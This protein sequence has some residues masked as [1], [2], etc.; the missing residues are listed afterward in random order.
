MFQNFSLIYSYTKYLLHVNYE[1]ISVVKSN[2][3]KRTFKKSCP[4]SEKKFLERD[5]HEKEIMS[6]Y[7]VSVLGV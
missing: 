6:Q 7:N 1:L 4:I 5:R 2:D 3:I